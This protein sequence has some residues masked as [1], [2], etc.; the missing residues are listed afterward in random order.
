MRYVLCAL[1]ALLLI[2]LFDHTMRADQQAM[3]QRLVAP[4]P[5]GLWIWEE[6]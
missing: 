6:L 1:L 3:C 5:S 4:C 2:A